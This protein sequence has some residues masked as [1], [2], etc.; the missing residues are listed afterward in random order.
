MN[1]DYKTEVLEKIRR[2]EVSMRPKIYF[3]AKLAV[4]IFLSVLLFLGLIFTLSFVFFS[5]HESGEQFLLGFG[6]RGVITFFELFPWAIIAF[7]MVVFF[8][9]EWT[10]RRF[11]FSYR[12]PLLRIF[13]YTIVA[14][15][16]LGILFTFTPAHTALLKKAEVGELP[17]VGGMY[18]AIHDSHQ[19]KGIVR[20]DIVS[21]GTNS[22]VITHNDN[23][24]DED[25]GTWNVV[26]P[27]GFNTSDLYVGEKV[28]VAGTITAS[29]SIN[30]YGVHE[31]TPEQ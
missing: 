22:L 9:L 10:L 26:L 24:K 23:D 3:I 8:L 7:C 15:V 12:L 16:V 27:L 1:K 28:Y 31:L 20:G 30:A 6:S 17:V 19:D 4:V 14:A 13:L 25:D 29:G 18:E 2:K 21:L 5:I 11:K